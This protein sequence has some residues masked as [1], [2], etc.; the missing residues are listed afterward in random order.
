[1]GGVVVLI[2]VA[3]AVVFLSKSAPAPAPALKTDSRFVF[4]EGRR[5]TPKLQSQFIYVPVKR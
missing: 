4:K 5:E 3:V 2:L 1:V